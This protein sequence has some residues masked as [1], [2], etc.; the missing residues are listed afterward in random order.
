MHVVIHEGNAKLRYF[1]IETSA[2]RRSALRRTLLLQGS[3]TERGAHALLDY[4]ANRILKVTLAQTRPISEITL[5]FDDDATAMQWQI[6]IR[7]AVSSTIPE[8]ISQ[9]S[10]VPRDPALSVC[11][12]CLGEIASSAD[13][14]RCPHGQHCIHKGECFEG[15]VA[16]QV[17]DA[18]RDPGLF[19]MR[20]NR[21]C[22]PA[23]PNSS[24]TWDDA[25]IQRFIK[26]STWQASMRIR[27]RS[28]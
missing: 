23:C 15:C 19:N 26:R 8:P 16:S 18:R 1:D 7:V 12:V 2:S 11:I 4:P 17:S 6:A 13:A 3:V 28:F 22:C 20:G 27:V 21:I 5:L 9:L 25:D 24:R 10:I 14:I